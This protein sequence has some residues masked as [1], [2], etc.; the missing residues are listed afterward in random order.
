MNWGTFRI[1]ILQRSAEGV[2]HFE[3]YF[4]VFE[5]G[6]PIDHASTLAGVCI[7]AD[8]TWMDTPH[9][10]KSSMIC[11]WIGMLLTSIVVILL[12]LNQM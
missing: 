7:Q 8:G 9:N 4:L 3:K 5:T 12:Y 6:R 2:E 11:E 10:T 1:L